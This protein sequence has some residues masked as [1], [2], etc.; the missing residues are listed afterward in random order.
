MEFSSD[1]RWK[2]LLIYDAGIRFLAGNRTQAALVRDQHANH[3]ATGAAQKRGGE[4]SIKGFTWQPYW[5]E[6]T[7]KHLCMKNNSFPTENLDCFCRPTWV[8]PWTLQPVDGNW[9]CLFVDR[10]SLYHWSWETPGLADRVSQ[11]WKGSPLQA[12]VE[13]DGLHL[14]KGNIPDVGEGGGG[15][16]EG[17]W[18]AQAIIPGGREHLT[19]SLNQENF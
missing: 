17:I 5:M 16:G 4:L 7:M 12:S 8:V 14:N 2:A 13:C 10:T 18:R 6:E 19:L 3:S 1:R 15:G 9:H 11:N